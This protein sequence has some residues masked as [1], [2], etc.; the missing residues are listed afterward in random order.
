MV[1]CAFPTDGCVEPERVIPPE[2]V[3][4]RRRQGINLDK[5]KETTSDKGKGVDPDAGKSIAVE[6]EMPVVGDKAQSSSQYTVARAVEAA[7]ELAIMPMLHARDA[8]PYFD[9]PIAE[10]NKKEC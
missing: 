1:P 7:S 4:P 6:P 3:D 5:R 8:P 2:L 9:D 10:G